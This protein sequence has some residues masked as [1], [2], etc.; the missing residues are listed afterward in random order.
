VVRPPHIRDVAALAG[1]GVGT[2]SRVLNDSAGVADDTRERVRAAMDDLGYRPSNAA[3]RLSLGR[4]QTLGVIAPFF[5][6]PSVVE[7]VRGIDDVVGDSAYD[8]VLFNVETSGQAEDALRRFARADRVDGVLVVSLPLSDDELTALQDQGIPVA[9]VDVDDERLPHVSNDDVLGG[10]LAARHLLDAGHRRVA[11]VG[12]T[13]ENPFGF[14][15]SAR[16][17]EGFAAAMEEAGAPLAPECIRR[18]PHGREV[19]GLLARELLDLGEPPTA[20]FAASDVQAFGVLDAAARA[21]LDVPGGVSVIGFDDIDLAGAIGLTTVRQPLRESGRAGA[22]LL[23]AAL[24][25]DGHEDA[26]ALPE[27]LVAARRTVGAPP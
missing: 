12:D 5:T 16:R 14:T 25:G 7:R 13:V 18:G 4:T 3:R 21:G 24:A 17:L 26:P 10:T 2:V 8:L 19:A 22:R 15:S 20:I 1:V 27:L 9:L 6:H 23:L 11:F